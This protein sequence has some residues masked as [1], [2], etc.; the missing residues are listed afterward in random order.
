MNEYFIQTSKS[1]C[2]P[3]KAYLGAKYSLCPLTFKLWVS[4]IK[5]TK[6]E[7]CTKESL[8]LTSS[9][10]SFNDPCPP[11]SAY[12][13]FLAYFFFLHDQSKAHETI[14]YPLLYLCPAEL[15]LWNLKLYS[16]LLIRHLHMDDIKYFNFWLSTQFHICLNP[17]TGSSS[18][19]S[20]PG[21]YQ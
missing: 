12:F 19:V 5:R 1:D 11:M 4:G 16:Q 20:S 14:S 7:H 8:I 17:L 10:F 6:Y 21:D 18:S 3:N 2:T 9:S 13:L 15:S